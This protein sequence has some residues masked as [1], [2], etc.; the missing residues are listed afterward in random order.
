ML[1]TFLS[2]NLTT[3]GTVGLIMLVSFL[4]VYVIRKRFGTK[5]ESLFASV[6]PDLDQEI[7]TAQVVVSKLLQSLPSVFIG[8]VLGAVTSGAAL[9]PALLG[10]LGG[11]LASFAHEFAKAMPFIPYT[12]ATG[13]SVKL[14]G[15]PKLPTGIGA[16]TVAVCVALALVTPGCGLLPVI[17]PAL[18]EAALVITDAVNAVDA[19]EALLPSLHLSAA[20]DTVL[21]ADI[22]KCR[23]ALAAAATADEG[24]KDL[25]EA[26]LD[27]SLADFRTAWADLET[28]FA[29]KKLAALS[30][31]IAVKRV[32][33]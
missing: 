21:E 22:A 27:A 33:Q 17:G 25:T 28:V 5:W 14:P 31:P 6:A 12:G 3:A 10:A 7:N 32:A 2:A 24:A 8:T 23:A 4:V 30:V 1:F 16:A 15:S 20:D 26:Q 11:L 18:S 29:A 19:A 9:V 13:G